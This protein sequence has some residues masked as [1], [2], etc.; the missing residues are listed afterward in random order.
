MRAAD[1]FAPWRDYSLLLL[2]TLIVYWPLSLNLL[3]LK[4]DALAQY[5]AYRYHLSEAIQNGYMPFW[6]PYIYTGFPVHAD[7]QGMVWN[8]VVIFLSFIS[9]YNMTVLQWEV[10]IYLYI[11]AL[12]MYRL[13][14]YLELSRT[15]AFCCA[16]SFLCCGYMTDSVSVIPWIPSAGF[17]P[18]V[19]LYFMRLLKATRFSDAIKFSF[20]LTLMFLCGYPSFFIFLNYILLFSFIG[21]SV[22]KIKEKNQKLAL[23][24]ALLLGSAYLIFILICSPAIVSYYEFLPYYSRGGGLAYARAATNPFVPFSLI[25]YITANAVSKAYFLPTDLS[26]RNAYIGLFIFLFFIISLFEL[27]KFKKTVLIFTVVAFLFS[28][29]NL[30]PF[31]KFFYDFVPLMN[32]FR[33]P[34][35]IRV[36]TSIGMII[37]AGFA[38]N[39]FLAAGKDR[40]VLATAFITL[41][42][43]L[44]AIIY[45]FIYGPEE[46]TGFVMSF[47]PAVLKDYLYR[48]SFDKFSAFILTVQLLFIITFISLLVRDRFTKKLFIGIVLLNSVLFGWMGLPFTVVS[49]YKTA[50]VN[51]Y[52]NAFPD[53]YPLINT[54]ASVESE[55]ISDSI[56]I[57]VHGYHNFYKKKITI[58]DHIKTPTLNRD[59]E[60]FLGDK[61]LRTALKGYPFV[62]MNNNSGQRIDASIR[63]SELNPN[64]FVFNIQSSSGGKLVLFQQYHHNWKATMDNK[65]VPI[66]KANLAFMSILVPA[67]DHVVQWEYKPVN[68]NTAIIVS[69]V[70]LLIILF[71]FVLT[72]IRK[73]QTA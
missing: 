29:G 34:G 33:H 71:Y 45:L 47:N 4:N 10:L 61:Q 30:I 51:N 46:D 3:S 73:K 56:E 17:I 39:K 50:D 62:Y 7:I 27:N 23:R 53:G 19:L 14:R 12:G 67:G 36:F 38:L 24:T 42:L 28:L 15:T 5:L 40:K 1:K 52:I 72:S 54:N 43:I 2:L 16:I 59:Y 60:I 26:M 31:Q 9:K 49:Q 65:Q 37:L 48:L 6:S 55:V 63:L 18:F 69:L 70:S 13:M 57:S 35:T 22:Y 41:V 11:A 20:S 68:V 21:W 25:S 44:V 58:Q 8:P 32:T 66:T 64:K